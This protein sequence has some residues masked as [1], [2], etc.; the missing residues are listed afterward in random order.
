VNTFSIGVSTIEPVTVK[1][2]PNPAISTLT[3]D[4]EYFPSSMSIV[5]MVGKTVLPPLSLSQ[6][7]TTIDIS[8]LP[9]GI[10]FIKIKIINNYKII[11][12]ITLQH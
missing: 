1:C 8:M 11:K 6:S 10:Y 9:A 3:I 7:K 4:T 2:Y 5:D 12:L